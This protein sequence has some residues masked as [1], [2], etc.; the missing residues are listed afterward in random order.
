MT[1]TLLQKQQPQS[2]ASTAIHYHIQDKLYINVKGTQRP[3]KP[4]I[5]RILCVYDT[6][7]IY[8]NTAMYAVLHM[9]CELAALII[10]STERLSLYYLYDS[11]PGH[12][13][14]LMMF[15]VYS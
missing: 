12:Y 5:P 4:Y 13:I 1:C 15:Y 11:I 7:V 9:N 8:N 10:R 3:S 14:F 2:E 6:P